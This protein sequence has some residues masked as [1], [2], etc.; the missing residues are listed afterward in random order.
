V[1]HGAG[2]LTL[3]LNVLGMEDIVVF[4]NAEHYHLAVAEMAGYIRDG[5]M[6]SKEDVV[7]RLQTF[8]ET[9]LKLFNGENFG[10]LVPQ[11][12]KG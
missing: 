2:G 5:H 1:A 9:L 8:P 3:W 11:V 10:K 12:A 6:K 7:A 4:D